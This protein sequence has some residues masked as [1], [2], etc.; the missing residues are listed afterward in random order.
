[1]DV[2]RRTVVV[3]IVLLLMAHIFAVFFG[4]YSS[5]LVDFLLHFLGGIWSALFFGLLYKHFISTHLHD[6]FSEKIKMLL[7]IIS[8]ASLLGIGWEFHEFILS[9][10]FP[11]YLQEDMWQVMNSLLVTIIGGGFGG[12]LI[13]YRKADS[14]DNIV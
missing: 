3:F 12:W 4:W 14:K 9:E 8:F 7:I 13:I 11:A 10:Y 1:M 2:S 6:H 5:S